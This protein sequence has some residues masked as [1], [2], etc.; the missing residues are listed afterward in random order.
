MFLLHGHIDKNEKNF[1]LTFYFQIRYQFFFDL[2]LLENSHRGTYDIVSTVGIEKLTLKDKNNN[3][4][5]E[6]IYFINF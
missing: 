2:G 5:S 1:I 3:K 6:C 4:C